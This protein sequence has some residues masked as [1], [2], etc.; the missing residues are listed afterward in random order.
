MLWKDFL[1]LHQVELFNMWVNWVPSKVQDPND[2]IK[3]KTY[4]VE[5]PEYEV[6]F[7]RDQEEYC[8]MG[9]EFIELIDRGNRVTSFE[10]FVC[11]AYDNSI[12]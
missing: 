9:D 7:D 10:D 11:F 8:E 3:Y 12:P 1:N 5:N 2:K 6:W 4:Y